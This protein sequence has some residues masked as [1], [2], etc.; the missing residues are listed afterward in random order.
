MRKVK[1]SMIKIF[2]KAVRADKSGVYDK[3]LT[4]KDKEIIS[5]KIFD[6]AWY[7]FETYKNCFNAV[8]TV[9]ARGNLEII[10]KWG[11][12]VGKDLMEKIYMPSLARKDLKSSLQLYNRLFKLWFNFGRQSIE[13]LS[14]NEV[15]LTYE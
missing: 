3:Y 15:N 4:D 8:A 6:S 14:D 10:K 5:E 1:G 11:V 7:P 12:D 9:F 2:V 13:F